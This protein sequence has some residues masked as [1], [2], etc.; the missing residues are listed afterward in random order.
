MLTSKSNLYN[1]GWL[2]IVF[3]NRNKE[4]GAYELRANYERRLIY[5]LFIACTA[6][7]VMIMMPYLKKLSG[8]KPDVVVAKPTEEV[9]RMVDV[10]LK[11]VKPKEPKAAGASPAVEKTTPEKVE[12]R[13]FTAA[14][15]VVSAAQP[16]NEIP[17]IEEL[18]TAAVGST[19]SK[20]EMAGAGVNASLSGSG[21]GT[22]SGQGT[23]M[24]ESSNDIFIGVEK[25]PEFAGG[26]QAFYKFLQRNLRYPADAQENN[27]TGKVVLSFVVEKD[28]SVSNI[29]V[30]KG[31][32]FGCD[33]EAVRVLKRS[34][35][36]QAGEQN[37]K[38]VRVQYTVPI[39]FNLQ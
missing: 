36:W 1:T 33:E 17:T 32:G 8:H 39:A 14:V 24:G 12:T 37:G 25:N 23:D 11:K 27:I 29:K 6:V 20:G 26:L 30:I 38:K 3:K 7:S 18:K 34:P 19:D 2:D 28:G 10:Q 15:K 31:I 22:G 13:K 35:K 5:S 21:T 9:F 4:Y 16:T